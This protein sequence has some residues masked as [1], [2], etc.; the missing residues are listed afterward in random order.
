LSQFGSTL[1]I[2]ENDH[3][4]PAWKMELNAKLAERR[5]RAGGRQVDG[6]AGQMSSARGKA[7]KVAARV[8]E[9]YAAAPTYSEMLAASEAA[10]EAAHQA[11]LAAEEA[12]AAARQVNDAAQVLLSNIEAEKARASHERG[13]W[14]FT[15]ERVVCGE[16][17]LVPEP[18]ETSGEAR[19]GA[20]GAAGWTVANAT[21]EHP[22]PLPTRSELPERPATRSF[23]GIVDAFAE[24]T[25]PAAKSLPTKL[26]EFPRELVAARKARP[27][28]AEGPL[29]EEP[30]SSSLR[31]FEVTDVLA[32][33]A[34]VV[35]MA[36]NYGSGE[37]RGPAEEGYGRGARR[38]SEEP[39]Y[40]G[41]GYGA[42]GWQSIRLGEH[43]VSE[44][45]NSPEARHEPGRGADREPGPASGR[46]SSRGPGR[47]S[48]RIEPEPIPGPALPLYV[49]TLGDRA[50]A[51]LVDIAIVGLAFATFAAVFSACTTH[52]QIDRLLLGGAAAV[53][54]GLFVLY[55]WLFLSYG[56]ATPGMRALRIAVC[57][58]DD[59]NPTRRVLR[60]RVAASLL[61]VLPLGLGV[62]WALFDEDGLGWHD[63]LTR[64]YQRSYR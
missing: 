21:I 59:E 35:P 28:I 13:A 16:P 15:E 6:P 26:I 52:L 1:Q 9:R 61:A 22:E 25:V 46:E 58:F 39:V 8:A 47:S 50:K 2:I 41:S 30:A 54:L 7:S 56:T 4:M 62:L 42:S 18:A 43:P 45:G 19:A 31:I 12:S 24:A 11:A 57:T 37:G 17:G 20:Y 29:L 48:V 53:L 23:R 63:R 36:R 64:S 44:R 49:A 10:A 32:V 60:G 33:G 55:G 51:A 27:R 34:E 5:R 40:G 3:A 38:P 14:E